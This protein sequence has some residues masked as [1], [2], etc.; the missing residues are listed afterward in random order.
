MILGLIGF[1]MQPKD[2]FQARLH[3]AL[4]LLDM[5]ATWHRWRQVIGHLGELFRAK[6]SPERSLD[7]LRHML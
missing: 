1:Q 3:L 2:D 5:F 7:S 4:T 6:D